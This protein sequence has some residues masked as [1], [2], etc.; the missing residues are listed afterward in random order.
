MPAR[1]RAVL[2]SPII[3]CRNLLF[4]MVVCVL[5]V[6][7]GRASAQTADGLASLSPLTRRTVEQLTALN[8]LPAAD[9][10]FHA[11]DV[12]HGEAPDLDD[13]SWQLSRQNRTRRWRRSGIAA[14]SKFPKTLNGYD[15]TGSRI[16]FQ[17][18]GVCQRA[19]AR[20]YL[21]QRAA[22]GARRRSG[23]DRALR[24]RPA[25]RTR[26]GRGQAAAHRRSERPSRAPM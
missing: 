25:R 4:V 18:R 7:A 22:R 16:W 1:R 24:S 13:S 11:G 8:Q 6:G 19:D 17:F 21:F 10:K 15:L 9:W 23:A 26:A 20:N 5:L 3:W 2:A 12:A 14:G